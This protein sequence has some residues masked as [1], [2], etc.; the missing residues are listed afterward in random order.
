MRLESNDYD[1]TTQNMDNIVMGSQE[2]AEDKEFA[3]D[4]QRDS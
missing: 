1:D 2:D 4:D 3:R